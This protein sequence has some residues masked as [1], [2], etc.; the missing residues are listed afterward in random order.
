MSSR[1]VFLVP[2]RKRSAFDADDLLHLRHVPN[3][4]DD[5]R[6]MLAAVDLDGQVQGHRGHRVVVHRDVHDVRVG[7]RDFRRQASQHAALIA[8]DDVQARGQVLGGVCVPAHID[9]AFGFAQALAR[10]HGAVGG[11]HHQPMAHA[12]ARHDRVAG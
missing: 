3:G 2:V 9:P 12:H 7:S 11:M 1:G 4:A 8:G 5:L 10:G 6:Q